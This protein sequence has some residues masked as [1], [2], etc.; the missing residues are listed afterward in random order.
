MSQNSATD[1]KKYVTEAF[2]SNSSTDLS[3]TNNKERMKTFKTL[4]L[5]GNS[6]MEHLLSGCKEKPLKRQTSML[7]HSQ[8]WDFGPI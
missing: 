4:S 8:K 2:Q 5:K 1:R 3:I 6:I 7:Y